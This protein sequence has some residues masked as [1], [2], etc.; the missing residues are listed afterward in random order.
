[1]AFINEGRSSID[2]ISANV[3]AWGRR[4]CSY[5]TWGDQTS[6]SS[7]KKECCHT[8]CH[9]WGVCD[10]GLSAD[11]T[12]FASDGVT[13]VE[14][15]VSSKYEEILYEMMFLEDRSTNDYVEAAVDDLR[16]QGIERFIRT[17]KLK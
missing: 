8:L 6:S 1:M 11:A 12:L 15:V 13:G 16:V 7:T 9:K 17:K 2:V 10:I 4:R 5:G 14:L 3:S